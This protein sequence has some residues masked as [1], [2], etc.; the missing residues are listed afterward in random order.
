MPPLRPVGQGVPG[1]SEVLQG[2]PT[3]G[4]IKMALKLSANT[5]HPRLKS[6]QEPLIIAINGRNCLWRA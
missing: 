2:P 3:Q 6:P 1:A 4:H 5:L